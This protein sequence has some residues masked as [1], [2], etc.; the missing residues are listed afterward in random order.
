M[1]SRERTSARATR[2]APQKAVPLDAVTNTPT[3]SRRLP[4]LLHRLVA[5]LVDETAPYFRS[6]GITIPATRVIVTLLENG[7]TMTVGKLSETLSIDLSTTSHILRRLE[8][9][10]YVA[11]QRQAHDNRIVN[12][13]LTMEGRR[14]AE[15]CRNA[16]F[17]HEEALVGDMSAQQ[18]AL[19]KS[20]L[21]TAYRNA[22][23]NLKKDKS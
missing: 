8:K 23:T 19:F 6:F 17:R 11:R 7:G 3:V 4:A 12:A 16:S 14:V 18:V 15:K 1:R 10:G 9:Q 21:E 2:S 20:M 5:L 22:R 13:V